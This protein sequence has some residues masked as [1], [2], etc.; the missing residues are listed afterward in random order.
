[1]RLTWT[2][3]SHNILGTA[4]S[5]GNRVNIVTVPVR[6]VCGEHCIRHALSNSAAALPA[7][8]TLSRRLFTIAS[9][10]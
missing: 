9:V 6:V 8:Q 7:Y 10:R 5:T 3:P 4:C 1:M 2:F